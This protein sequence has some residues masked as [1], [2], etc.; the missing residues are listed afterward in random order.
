MNVEGV[1]RQSRSFHMPPAIRSPPESSDRLVRSVR[2]ADAAGKRQL[3][4]PVASIANRR[5][6]SVGLSRHAPTS[7]EEEENHGAFREVR[8]IRVVR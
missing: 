7:F 6:G 2:N 1:Y 3:N 8:F 5:N 4:G